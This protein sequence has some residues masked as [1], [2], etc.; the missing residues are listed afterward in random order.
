MPLDGNARQARGA[1]DEAKL[2]LVWTARLVAEYRKRAEDVVILREE[3]RGP[4]ARDARHA[5][6][7]APLGEKRTRGHVRDDHLHTRAHRGAA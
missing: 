6:R 2:R 4:D 7:I 1:I 5:R 3:R